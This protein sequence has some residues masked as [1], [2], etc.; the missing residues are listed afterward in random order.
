MNQHIKYYLPF[1]LLLNLNVLS[2][3]DDKTIIEDEPSLAKINITSTETT[4]LMGASTLLSYETFDE[5]DDKISDLNISWHSTNEKIAVI[6]EGGLLTTHRLGTVEVYASSNSIESNYIAVFVTNEG[7]G[8]TATGAIPPVDIVFV[9]DL[10]SNTDRGEDAPILFHYYV[11]SDSY[12]IE[13]KIDISVIIDIPSLELSNHRLFWGGTNFFT[14]DAP[15]Y[16]PSYDFFPVPG[17]LYDIDGNE[18]DS[19]EMEIDGD[20]V[21]YFEAVVQIGKLLPGNYLIFMEFTERNQAPVNYSFVNPLELMLGAIDVINL[22][23]P[24]GFVS[25]QIEIFNLFPTF[26]WTTTGCKNALRVSEYNQSEHF[27]PEDALNAGAVLPYPDDGG[28]FNLG[29]TTSY[30]YI[31]GKP[32]EQN[33]T[34]VWQVKKSCRTSS[35]DADLLSD[36]W[37]FTI[38]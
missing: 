32:L 31:D 10:G 26:T 38:R 24:G 37:G 13:L 30:T 17:S 21:I 23:A 4:L 18:I 25:E 8:I 34:Y 11:T 5:N 15:L 35:G 33:K 6:S 14:L 20:A 1:L 16:L 3:D 19:V 28:Y 9:G 27:S 22:I 7:D 12:P 2:C 29:E 36:I